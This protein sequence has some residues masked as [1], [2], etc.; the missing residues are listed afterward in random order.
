MEINTIHHISLPVTDVERAKRFYRE[1]LGLRELE[2]PPFDFPGAWFQLGDDQLHLIVHE[3]STLRGAKGLDSRDVHFA[4]RVS[5]FR[6]ALQVL[7]AKGY[8]EDADDDLLKM[9]VSPHATAGFPQIYIL[10]PDR[11]VIEI[12]AEQLDLDS[13]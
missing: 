12:N 10:D 6:A 2:R 7:E 5:S 1:T 4:V 11:N 8:R 9:K 13:P 3:G